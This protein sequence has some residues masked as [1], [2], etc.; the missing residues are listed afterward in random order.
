MKAM[1]GFKTAARL[2]T[3]LLLLGTLTAA[4]AAET[5][6]FGLGILLGEPTALTAKL[7]LKRENALDFGLAF[8]FN[9]YVLLYSDYLFHFPGTFKSTSPFVNE[10]VPYVG[11][12]GILAFAKDRYSDRDRRFFGRKR[13]SLG[14]GLRVPVGIEWSPTRVPLGVFV[15]LVPGISLIPET[16]GLFEGGIGARYFF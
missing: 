5:R 2:S 9:D 3:L 16:S 11:V 13:D 1:Y 7:W 10:L 15:E 4:T 14:L 12:G 6:G 8:S